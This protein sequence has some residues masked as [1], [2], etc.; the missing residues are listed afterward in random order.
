MKLHSYLKPKKVCAAVQ[1]RAKPVF[2]ERTAQQP[3]AP[4]GCIVLGTSSVPGPG[5]VLEPACS[6]HGVC[7]ARVLLSLPENKGVFHT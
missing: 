4:V 3:R 5:S 7:A 1:L 6:D 2:P